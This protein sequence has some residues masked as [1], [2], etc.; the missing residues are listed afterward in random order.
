MDPKDAW[1]DA[2]VKALG[3]R[4]QFGATELSVS[5]AAIFVVPQGRLGDARGA[6][7]GTRV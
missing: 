6:A 2:R 5:F 3:T 4:V 7:L 1:G